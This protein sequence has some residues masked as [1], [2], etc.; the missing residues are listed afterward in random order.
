MVR[1]RASYSKTRHAADYTPGLDELLMYA[2]GAQGE[3]VM[4]GRYRVLDVASS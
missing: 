1:A 2:R 4:V 3:E